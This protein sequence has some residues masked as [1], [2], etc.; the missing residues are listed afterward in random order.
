MF[1]C[2]LPSFWLTWSAA[3][4]CR[5]CICCL[6]PTC[7]SQA[8]CRLFPH[9]TPG[10]GWRRPANGKQTHQTQE[11]MGHWEWMQ[12]RLLHTHTQC[13]TH[14]DTH[15]HARLY[16]GL[17]VVHVSIVRHTNTIHIVH[18][19]SHSYVRTHCLVHTYIRYIY[20][21]GWPLILIWG[22][23]CGSPCHCKGY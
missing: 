8:P 2:A 4:C 19:L 16:P 9:R 11:G 23:V 14:T 15:T 7:R 22:P 10:S 17:W 18:N 3:Q 1:F 12:Y 6:S 21:N 20:S 5:C 13:I